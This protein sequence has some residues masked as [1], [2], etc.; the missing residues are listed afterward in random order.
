MGNRRHLAACLALALIVPFPG[1]AVAGDGGLPVELV[2]MSLNKKTVPIAQEIDEDPKDVSF[3]DRQKFKPSK[4]SE[5]GLDR[6]F[7][8]Q[9]KKDGAAGAMVFERPAT[10]D[11]TAWIRVTVDQLTGLDD[12]AS[13]AF[14]EMR[15]LGAAD[16][17]GP[18]RL[19]AI[20]D[21][22]I[23][24]FNVSSP[25][26]GDVLAFPGVHELFL[27]IEDDGTDINLFAADVVA[28]TYN[29]FG[30]WQ[31]VH[32]VTNSRPDDPFTVAFGV[33]GLLKKARIYFAQLVLSVAKIQPGITETL[34]GEELFLVL[35]NLYF[36]QNFMQA[37]TLSTEFVDL[38]L[39]PAVASAGFVFLQSAL[40]M[41]DDAEGGAD[42]TA[43]LD[44]STDT[45]RVRKGLEKAFIKI[46]QAVNKMEAA[47]NKA[48]EGGHVNTKPLRKVID[49]S[50]DAVETATA[51]LFG[52][53]Q[54]SPKKLDKTAEVFGLP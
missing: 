2:F 6:R 38:N 29:G 9:A 53:K 10:G 14:F 34:I 41:L 22:D 42:G 48:G 44:P 31:P 19:E 20:W 30:I 28:E 36:A 18:W 13:L 52:Y 25:L 26:G 5:T 16:A 4:G 1:C 51:Q 54:K 43:P 35:N 15:S 17:G 49:Q 24:G 23:D 45:A 11:L 8:M 12:D 50:V 39:S 21:A 46:N 47:V 3:K 32:S 27:V 33:E 37:R 7:R 40:N